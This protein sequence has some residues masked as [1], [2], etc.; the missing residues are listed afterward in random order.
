MRVRTLQDKA[1]RLMTTTGHLFEEMMATYHP[2]DIAGK[3]TGKSSNTQWALRQLWK[4]C[5]EEL[6]QDDLSSVFWTVGDAG[7]H[8]HPRFLRAVIVEFGRPQ[9]TSS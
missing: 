3:V 5:G 2:L 1:E 7:T 6:H 4:K 9:N 8:R